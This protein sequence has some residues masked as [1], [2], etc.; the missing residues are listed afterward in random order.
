MELTII[1][2]IHFEHINFVEVG[3]NSPNAILMAALVLNCFFSTKRDPN[4]V[5]RWREVWL[6]FR[7]GPLLGMYDFG[8]CH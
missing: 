5:V 2:I 1:L 6:I 7:V 3:R 8:R 4:M